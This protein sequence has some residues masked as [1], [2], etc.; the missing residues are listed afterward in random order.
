MYAVRELVQMY[1]SFA[2]RNLRVTLYPSALEAMENLYEQGDTL[3][4]A[5]IIYAYRKV[6]NDSKRS[7]MNTLEII[8]PVSGENRSFFVVC[9]LD[10]Q[11]FE[12]EFVQEL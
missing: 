9:K 1:N 4:V 10:E 5:V 7:Q 8:D 11:H 2:A 3:V 6:Q 12:V